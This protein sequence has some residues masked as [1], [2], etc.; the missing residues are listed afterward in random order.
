MGA[1]FLQRPA[2][3]SDRL[4]VRLLALAAAA[5]ALLALG[6]LGVER[7]SRP[8]VV[9]TAPGL[10][11]GEAARQLERLIAGARQRVWCAVYVVRPDGDGP[12][13]G[14]MEAL[15]AAAA[16]GVDVR[17]GLD[18]G[19]DPVTKVDD[20]RNQDAA[21]WLTAHGVRVVWDEPTVTSHMKVV[22]VDGRW[23]VAGS[24]NWT[25]A[26]LTANRELGLA[27]DDPAAAAQAEA[28]LAGFPDWNRP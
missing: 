5:L 27:I 19:P 14:L 23:L 7:R 4:V 28:L 13:H 21:R 3:E 15:A 9:A 2:V 22:V 26:A 18:S 12:V 25:R 11:P 1:P 10:P 20:G 6:W 8:Q 17:V 16:R 24:H